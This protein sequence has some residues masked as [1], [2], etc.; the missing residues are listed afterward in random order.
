MDK[1]T[2]LLY[3]ISFILL[4]YIVQSSNHINILLLYLTTII[5]YYIYTFLLC[6]N[7]IRLIIILW[8]ARSIT[9][10]FYLLAC[11]NSSITYFN[12]YNKKSTKMPLLSSILK[13]LGL[14]LEW[15]YKRFIKESKVISLIVYIINKLID[16]KNITIKLIKKLLIR[17]KQRLIE[18]TVGVLSMLFLY[19]V[20]IDSYT[21]R[22]KAS[23][24]ERET[25]DYNYELAHED[26]QEEILE[27]ASLLW[28]H[29]VNS[30]NPF[31]Y[32]DSFMETF[33]D[34]LE[35]F[36]NYWSNIIV[37]QKE[38]VSYINHD[39]FSHKPVYFKF[40]NFI[41]I[42]SSIVSLP[43]SLYLILFLLPVFIYVIYF[44]CNFLSYRIKK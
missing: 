28:E 9:V 26:K 37:K 4:T 17:F 30:I 6:C 41:D 38:H 16:W 1:N 5:I 32:T 33:F 14:L 40:N 21:E 39:L 18:L 43:S 34:M 3:I 25:Y 35:E 10:L 11:Y 44:T 24:P 22:W 31:Y 8:Y 15:F 2:M 7:W 19:Y 12:V 20:E 27:W 23:H 29:Y 13:N 42:Y 36:I